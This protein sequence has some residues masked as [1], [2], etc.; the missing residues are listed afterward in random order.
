MWE[1]EKTI[2]EIEDKIVRLN[3]QRDRVFNA[4]RRNYK[5]SWISGHDIDFYFILLRRLFRKI[6]EDGETNSEIEELK[7]ENEE[8]FEKIRIRDS[9][10]H[11]RDFNPEDSV[12]KISKSLII[13][14]I[15]GTLSIKAQSGIHRWNLT[16]DHNDFIEALRKATSIKIKD[17]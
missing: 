1:K 15:N 12:I 9:Y 11:D 8:L 5:R 6:D 17:L 10:E 4:I 7:E 14:T 16:E 2:R 3:F 13:N